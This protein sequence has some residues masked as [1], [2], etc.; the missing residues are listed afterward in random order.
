MQEIR[1]DVFYNTQEDGC[2]QDIPEK[3]HFIPKVTN[4]GKEVK[5][6]LYP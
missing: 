5:L 6:Y 4:R 3:V 2:Y 1:R